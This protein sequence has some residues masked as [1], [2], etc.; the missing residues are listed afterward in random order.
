MRIEQIHLKVYACNFRRNTCEN[1]I[2]AFLLPREVVTGKGFDVPLEVVATGFFTSVDSD[3][4][5]LGP[6]A[7]KSPENPS[8]FDFE[9][10]GGKFLPRSISRT[11]AA[12]KLFKTKFRICIKA[13]CC[14]RVANSS[15]AY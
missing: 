10:L 8:G 5:C 3:R 7:I 4:L 13:F 15:I 9:L 14:C 6:R 2:F 11:C 1:S 12:A